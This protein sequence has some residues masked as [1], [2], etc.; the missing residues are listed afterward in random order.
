MQRLFFIGSPLH[1]AHRSLRLVSGR[2]VKGEK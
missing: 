1:I 2:K